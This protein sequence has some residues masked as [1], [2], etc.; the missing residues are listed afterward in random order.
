LATWIRTFHVVPSKREDEEIPEYEQS[1]GD[2][3]RWLGLADV[4]IDDSPTNIID[5]N[6]LGLLGILVC[7]PWNKSRASLT[8][9]LEVLMSLV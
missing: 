1:K 9:S 8:D 3:L 7:Q 6:N 4:L 5:A 2:F